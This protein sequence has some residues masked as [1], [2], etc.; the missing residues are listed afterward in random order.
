MN[1][2]H[3]CLG[4]NPWEGLR[5][6]IS[7]DLDPGLLCELIGVNPCSVIRHPGR[8]AKAPRRHWDVGRSCACTGG[9]QTAPCQGSE[10]PDVQ[11][12]GLLPQHYPWL[13]H[14]MLSCHLSS[15]GSNFDSLIPQMFS[16]LCVGPCR[17]INPVLPQGTCLSYLRCPKGKSWTHK[18][19]TVCPAA[20]GKVQPWSCGT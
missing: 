14:S 20:A 5:A 7:V 2:S 17:K 1:H 19:G 13:P 18:S 15:L 16:S 6:Q 9:Q 10:P 4:N 11:E 8:T 3:R 12:L